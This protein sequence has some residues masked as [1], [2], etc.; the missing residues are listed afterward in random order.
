MLRLLCY[1]F[2]NFRGSKRLGFCYLLWPRVRAQYR[3]LSR[4]LLTLCL[5]NLNAGRIN[6][7]TCA[8][9]IV[10]SSPFLSIPCSILK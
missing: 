9:V 7:C 4:F 10:N 3:D 8:S 6:Y 5:S 2:V 1:S